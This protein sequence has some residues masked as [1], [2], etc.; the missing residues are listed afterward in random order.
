MPVD[1]KSLQS[2]LGLT[3]FCREFIVGYAK[4]AGPQ[5][6]VLKRVQWTWT[7]E[8]PGQTHAWESLK[9]GLMEAPTLAAAE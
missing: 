3:N 7:K 8:G 9:K 2:F 1:T 6:E 4:K 5:Y